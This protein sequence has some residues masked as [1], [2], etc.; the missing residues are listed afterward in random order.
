M[1]GAGK[2][3]VGPRLAEGLGWRYVDSDAQVEATVG[4]TVAEIFAAEGEA[5]FRGLESAALRTAL[6]DPAP[7][8]VSVAGGAVLDP[9]NRA[10][11]REA[12]TVMWLKA[13]VATLARRVGDGSG[14]PLLEG[15]P[16]AALARLLEVR[17]PLYAEVADAVVEVDGL[18]ESEVLDRVLSAVRGLPL[19][20]SSQEAVR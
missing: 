20:P 2:S 1:M 13:D 3:T 10:L 17:A 6:A 19:D 11:L 14:R 8:V 7:S 12:G 16:V 15:D 5:G 9:A 18:S 4:R